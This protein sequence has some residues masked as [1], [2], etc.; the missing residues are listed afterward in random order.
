MKRMKQNLEDEVEER[1]N[2]RRTCSH[3]L[4]F[5]KATRT[6]V[7]KRVLQ[8]PSFSRNVTGYF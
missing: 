2:K 6:I 3:F 8:Y 4:H 5:G 7:P 1:L